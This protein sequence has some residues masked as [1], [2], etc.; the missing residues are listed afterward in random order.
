MTRSNF[1]RVAA[2]GMQGNTVN[3]RIKLILER[4]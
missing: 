2:D 1:C 4:I 3:A